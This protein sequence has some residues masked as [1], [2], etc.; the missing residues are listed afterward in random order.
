MIWFLV[1]SLLLADPMSEG[2]PEKTTS[3]AEKSEWFEDQPQNSDSLPKAATEQVGLADAEWIDESADF[4][5]SYEQIAAT[6]KT[7]V[8]DEQRPALLLK[9]RMLAS[10]LRSRSLV[11]A[12]SAELIERYPES[13]ETQYVISTFE[14]PTKLKEF[15]H[16]LFLSNLLEKGQAE[17][18]VQV[19]R[20]LYKLHKLDLLKENGFA[21]NACLA[22][23]L[24]DDQLIWNESRQGVNGVAGKV[25]DIAADESLPLSDRFHQLETL[26]KSR[27]RSQR[28]ELL[29]NAQ[30]YLTQK[31]SS[32]ERNDLSVRRVVAERLLD[33]NKLDLASEEYTTLVKLTDDPQI[34]AQ[35]ALCLARQLRFDEAIAQCKLVQTA[36][37]DSPWRTVVE[38]L[39]SVSQTQADDQ[40]KAIKLI[41][42]CVAT[43]RDIPL[44]FCDIE[45]QVELPDRQQYLLNFAANFVTS[46]GEITV[47]RDGE[48]QLGIRTSKGGTYFAQGAKHP[49]RYMRELH[50]TPDLVLS[51]ARIDE[52]GKFRGDFRVAYGTS[53]GSIPLTWKQLL[54]NNK[55]FSRVPLEL[56]LNSL[57]A[58]G[59]FASTTQ[60]GDE[61]SVLELTHF[62]PD[63]PTVLRSQIV[64]DQSRK[65]ESAR[66]AYKNV[67]IRL[68]RF[69]IGR[70]ATEPVATGRW[71]ASLQSGPEIEEVGI[72]E[73]AKFSGQATSVA[74]DLFEEVMGGKGNSFSELDPDEYTPEPKGK[75]LPEQE[76]WF[77][78][79]SAEPAEAAPRKEPLSLEY[80]LQGSDSKP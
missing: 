20:G 73:M 62:C 59:S 65:I 70:R 75:A 14:S 6:L 61:R 22:A 11:E 8:V 40:Q 44:G 33:T 78:R 52:T 23:L 71:P 12:H 69:R 74:L 3:A 34:H 66:L 48:L 24:A 56:F 15:V 50:V 47:C 21:A 35:Y 68:K 53:F 17:R 72:G 27:K 80:I 26:L 36:T 49:L 76:P 29:E 51:G 19:I 28:W 57:R 42:D 43:Y 67:V 9:A 2:L 30:F 31:M 63:E 4:E 13:I 39:I 37:A 7:D 1:T 25:L 38:A 54:R 18:A 16:T 41:S 46:E 60:T 55:L 10:I 77:S 64:F 79:K 5:S 45:V 58:L 32:D